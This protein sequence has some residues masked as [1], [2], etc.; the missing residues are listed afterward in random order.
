M[1]SEGVLM[2]AVKAANFHLLSFWMNESLKPTMAAVDTV[3]IRKLWPEK[4]VTSTP[5]C[6]RASRKCEMRW[7]QLSGVPSWNI[8]SGPGVDGWIAR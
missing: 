4:L 5:I 3:P 2:Y 6:A 7:T 8:N 1:S